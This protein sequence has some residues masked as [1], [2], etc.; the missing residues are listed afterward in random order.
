MAQF[1]SFDATCV[2]KQQA[3]HQQ[4]NNSTIGKM[5]AD[6]IALQF[7][8][9]QL[10]SNPKFIS[11]QLNSELNY[12]QSSE[13]TANFQPILNNP[14]YSSSLNVNY[15]GCVGNAGP[16]RP[17]THPHL[18]Q[19]VDREAMFR[20]MT[21]ADGKDMFR[22]TSQSQSLAMTS[23]GQ[24]MAYGQDYLSAQQFVHQSQ[25][26]NVGDKHYGLEPGFDTSYFSGC[27]Q[28][29]PFPPQLISS[30]QRSSQFPPMSA[31][32]DGLSQPQQQQLTLPV[33]SQGHLAA[34]QSHMPASQPH[35]PT[36][37]PNNSSVGQSH[38][39]AWMRETKSTAKSRRHESPSPGRSFNLL[40]I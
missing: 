7:I 35:L 31:P 18:Q 27:Q 10:N 8:N 39:Y 40:L 15:S 37:I 4:D 3:L 12:H 29:K 26:P 2:R 5:A 14:V 17:P 11:Q 23:Q 30:E 32:A 20:W 16:I 24:P 22:M 36:A 6:D 34:L 19:P 1:D 9:Q 33:C 28:F 21:Q 25:Q 13:S 38:V